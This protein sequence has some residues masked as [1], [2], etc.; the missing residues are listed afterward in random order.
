MCVDLPFSQKNS[1]ILITLLFLSAPDIVKRIGFASLLVGPD[2]RTFLFLK[3]QSEDLY[4]N[5][6]YGFLS[7]FF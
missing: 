2:M 4:S 5:L 3:L 1:V 6:L 7:T